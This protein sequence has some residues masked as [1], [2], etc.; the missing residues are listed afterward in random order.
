MKSFTCYRALIIG[1]LF[2]IAF[3]LS[4]LNAQNNQVILSV[5]L[6]D[7]MGGTG[8]YLAEIYGTD[9]S[10]IE[11]DY[12]LTQGS[13]NFVFQDVASGTY[14]I[15]VYR[16]GYQ[17]YKH[18]SVS[19]NANYQE[20]IGLQKSLLPPE[21]LTVNSKSL[22]V[23]WDAPQMVLL[24]ENFEDTVFPPENWQSVE[25]TRADNVLYPEIGTWPSHF[26]GEPV[27]NTSAI[28]AQLLTPPIDMRQ[29]SHF[30]LCFDYFFRRI[31]PLSAYVF[32]SYD[33]DS[34][35]Y[36]L[37]NL[38][39]SP[40]WQHVCLDLDDIS[41]VNGSRSVIFNF[42][43]Q[44]A[45]IYYDPAAIDNV[46]LKSELPLPDNYMLLLDSM[47]LS[48]PPGTAQSDTLPCMLYNEQHQVSLAANYSCGISDTVSN[49]FT[50]Y[51]LPVVEKPFFTYS[52]GDSVVYFQ[53]HSVDTCDSNWQNEGLL[54]FNLFL[55]GN[56][57]GNFPFIPE[58]GD[59]VYTF[60]KPGM[61][62]HRYCVSAVYDL[63]YWGFA[64]QTGESALVCDTVFVAYGKFIPFTEDW[65]SATF[66]LN[67]W[68]ADSGFTITSD[69]GM[70]LP[71]AVFS[72]LQEGQHYQSFLTSDNLLTD[73]F[74]VGAVWFDYNVK[75]QDIS[76]NYYQCYMSEVRDVDG[77]WISFDMQHYTINH[78][79]ES[80]HFDITGILPGNVAAVR[81]RV[82]GN[83]SN[84]LVNWY[85]DN[86]QI[87]RSCQSPV[88]LRAD[89]IWDGTFGVQVSWNFHKSP[90]P[91]ENRGLKGFN[92][93][94]K[95]DSMS[96][97]ELYDF[98]PFTN[99]GDVNYRDMYP[100]VDPYTGYFYKVCAFYA[101][102]DDSLESKFAHDQN[103][104]DNDYVY[105]L[106]TGKKENSFDN[107][108]VV[109]PN[110]ARKEILV[111][112]SF[113]MDKVTLFNN[114]GERVFRYEHLNSKEIDLKL[115]P[116]SLGIYF[117]KIQ[118]YKKMV[119]KKILIR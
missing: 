104:P 109:Y 47:A 5:T 40:F 60:D 23:S 37:Y 79:W 49:G 106:I 25:F 62:N 112:A 85:F 113:V 116:L 78:D 10:G 105:V 100:D 83:G 29:A 118:G 65:S 80:K 52:Y 72:P 13:G 74:K 54:S 28:W 102:E 11:R 59:I 41:G 91:N 95:S 93:Y 87:Y 44:F 111:S 67:N 33:N 35:W 107:Q 8:D 86:I 4:T 110:P 26:A 101:D 81:F 71:A 16:E 51:R 19:I 42:A 46:E 70:P 66:E 56:L 92:I 114:K 18:D 89:Y 48:Q 38:S 90:S 14:E 32:V 68:H 96:D 50:S 21:N 117:L 94:R 57:I 75:S 6:C 30:K 1:L 98:V 3:S 7:T 108:V 76:N 69:T 39:P 12:R 61:G 17:L 115:P 20:V 9:L 43:F 58:Q 31:Y 77:N 63:T 55:D 64:G 82:E 103:Q 99:Q 84:P 15:A 2:T 73:R 119:S 34:I 36:E 45:M 53:L 88:K 22:I 97:Y 27:G 24:N